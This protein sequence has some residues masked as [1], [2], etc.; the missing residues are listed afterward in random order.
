MCVGPRARRRTLSCV[1]L[2]MLG[3]AATGRAQDSQYWDIQYGPV[4]QLLGGQIV[5][6]ARDLSAAYYN[7]GGLALGENPNF[8]LSVQAVSLRRYKLE[9]VEG[10]AYLNTSQT[11][12]DT[13]PGFVAFSL[14][15]GWL[16]ERN[17]LAFSLL[18]RQQLNL[19]LDQRFAGVAPT[20]DGQYG[21]ETLLDQRM[22]E[23]WGGLT[24]S[25]RFSNSLGA[26]ATLFGVYRGQR[27][28]WEQSL[29]LDYTDGR[30]VATL[31]VDDFDYS[32]WRVLGKLGIAWEGKTA[33]FGVAVTTPSAGLFG[34]GKAGFTRS[35]SGADLNG[36][37]QVD[38]L[39][40]NGLDEDVSARYRSSWALA[41]GASWRSG[42][43]QL[44][45]SA[46]WFAAVDTFAVLEGLSQTIGGTPLTLT[47]QLQSVVNFGAAVE[48][49]LGGVSADRGESSRATALYGSFRTDFSASPDVVVD[50]A[51]T[52]NQDLFHVTAGSAFSLAGS[53]FSVGLE[54][55]F[56]SK[57]RDFSVGNL[58]SSVPIVGASMP[59]DVRVA[60][61]VL[62]LGYLFG[63]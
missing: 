7:P 40:L 63:K 26:G 18:T 56:G 44:H 35:V 8:L 34:S 32:D 50:E 51:A 38:N 46:E 53:R 13:F 20:N 36:D 28:R 60:R 10:G 17:R 5:G 45:G 1:L 31:A 2:V 29:Q 42:S 39:L 15:H 59:I 21:L 6:S 57:H 14:P 49:W 11:D 55:T 3:W 27:T 30:G 37:G 19:R 41:A 16:G 48:Y 43:L 61:W 9:P 22:A 62:V 4:G 47:Q 54:Y 24:L 58:P 33:R 23:T 52:S 12:F 25:H